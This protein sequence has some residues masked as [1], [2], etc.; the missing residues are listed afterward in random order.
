MTIRLTDC[1]SVCIHPNGKY[2][3]LSDFCKKIKIIDIETGKCIRT[4]NDGR[5]Y[6]TSLCILTNNHKSETSVPKEQESET[7]VSKE[8][9]SEASVPKEQESETSVSKKHKSETSVPKEQE[10]ETSVSKEPNKNDVYLISGTLG[11]LG[12]WHINSGGLQSEIEQSVTYS[13]RSFVR[14]ICSIPGEKKQIIC[15]NQDNIINIYNFIDKNFDSEIIKL[16]EHKET[17]SSLCAHPN[18]KQIISGSMD[19]CIKIWDL[20]TRKCIQTLNTDSG[21]KAVYSIGKKI[22]SGHSDGTIKI[23]TKKLPINIYD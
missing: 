2:I 22:I 7:S 1:I 12:I 14:F 21:V 3:I 18:G 20:E 17:V 4:M 15:G 13:D 23:W 11:S 6:V 19:N 10:S 8:H 16:G 5:S 9:K